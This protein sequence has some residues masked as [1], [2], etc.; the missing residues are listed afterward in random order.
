MIVNDLESIE[1]ISFLFNKSIVHLLSIVRSS[2]SVRKHP[3]F[4]KI[5]YAGF[6]EEKKSANKRHFYLW[7][8]PVLLCLKTLHEMYLLSENNFPI[9]ITQTKH[10]F[11]FFHSFFLFNFFL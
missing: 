6:G 7:E 4:V 2:N 9:R 1:I 3:D 5:L 10:Y 11:P 8:N